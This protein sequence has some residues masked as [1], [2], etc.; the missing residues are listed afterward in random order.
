VTGPQPWLDK[1]HPMRPFT[2]VSYMDTNDRSRPGLALGDTM[3][4]WSDLATAHGL[5]LA[6]ATM[7]EL[8]AA[9]PMLEPRLAAV[10]D[11]SLATPRDLAQVRPA[12]P[13]VGGGLFCSGPN[14]R[15]HLNEM[16]AGQR[17]D[18][19]KKV[20]APFFFSKPAAH[21]IIGP[22]APIVLPAG[23]HKL[24]WEAEL[25]VVIGRPARDV[26]VERAMDHVFGY[27]ILNDLSARDLFRREEWPGW[28]DWLSCKGF[29]GS[30][31]LGPAIVPAHQVADPYA[32]TVRL[33]VNDV[34]QQEAST[35]QMIFSIAEQIAYLSRRVTLRPGDLI[36]TG[37]PAGVGMPRNVFLQPGDAV[38]V[39]IEGLGIGPLVNPVV[40]H[41][42]HSPR[43]L[44]P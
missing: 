3:V 42:L 31:P 33:W 11:G 8:I 32:L 37:T 38:R 2:L 5:P 23:S 24:D 39:E 14:Y 29:E 9:W 26:P 12:P 19:D 36:A 10:E 7:P 34:L 44:Q 35:D 22:G 21:S 28:L 15:C 40:A 6:E 25:A 20:A 18:I 13:V 4:A 16:T 43:S 17:S 41:P 27:S 1:E 30:A